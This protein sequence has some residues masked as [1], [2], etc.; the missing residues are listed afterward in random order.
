MT[1]KRFKGFDDPAM[2][3]LGFAGERE[4]ACFQMRRAFESLRK[5]GHLGVEFKAVPG[6]GHEVPVGELGGILDRFE[7]LAAERR[8]MAPTLRAE[9]ETARKALEGKGWAEAV[10]VLLGV[11][12]SGVHGPFAVEA[13]GLLWKAGEEGN[14]RIE[15]ALKGEGAGEREKAL[16]ALRAVARDFRGLPCAAKAEEAEQALLRPARDR[17]PGK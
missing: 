11:A 3:V 16:E 6:L 15:A 7:A 5:A 13:R 4:P 8:E 9:L 12:D 10:P 1:G 17:G 14:R 2:P